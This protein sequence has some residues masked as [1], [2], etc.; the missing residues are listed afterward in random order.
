[1]K[2]YDRLLKRALAE[3][4]ELVRKYQRLQFGDPIERALAEADVLE[5]RALMLRLYVKSSQAIDRLVEEGVLV[6]AS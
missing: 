3:H 5:S 4:D 2:D 1:M 6:E